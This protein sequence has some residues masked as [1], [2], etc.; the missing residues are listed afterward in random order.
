MAFL[1]DALSHWLNRE[2][3]TRSPIVSPGDFNN[4]ARYRQSQLETNL[5]DGWKELRYRIRNW[6][7]L[8]D[9]DVAVIFGEQSVGLNEPVLILGKRLLA[10]VMETQY[11]W[12]PIQYFAGS[13]VIG[14]EPGLHTVTVP[15]P[16]SNS[17]TEKTSVI[18]SNKFKE[19]PTFGVPA[20]AINLKNLRSLLSKVYGN[21]PSVNFLLN[22]YEL[23]RKYNTLAGVQNELLTYFLNQLFL[24]SKHSYDDIDFDTNLAQSGGLELIL[25][26]WQRILE[27]S[28][29]H[30]L[31]L[32]NDRLARI[33]DEHEMPFFTFKSGHNSE[34]H[35]V[36]SPDVD[37]ESFYATP[38]N[39]PDHHLYDFSLDD[40][41]GGNIPITFRAIPRVILFASI[42]DA[43]I[44][45]GGSKYNKIVEKVYPD[46]FGFEYYPIAHMDLVNFAGQQEAV[47]QYKS[48]GNRKNTAPHL[49]KST[50]AVK[51]GHVSSLDMF[52]SVKPKEAEDIIYQTVSD[53]NFQMNSRVDLTEAFIY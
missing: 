38:I 34:R 6:L 1:E 39:K 21:N 42:F 22:Q 30:K 43:H 15:N 12:T 41:L 25:A 32:D 23:S 45:A 29:K 24:D 13:D 28:K 37:R 17:G 51:Q 40:I 35:R 47:F 18:S 5:P 7:G 8:T 27:L 9:T 53:P 36:F 4:I 33:P 48:A 31:A 14:S 46:L 20:K 19:T 52:L 49:D 10:K 26:V 11:A 2:F 16:F 3:D 50:E 44:T